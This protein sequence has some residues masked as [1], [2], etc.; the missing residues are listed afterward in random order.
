MSALNIDCLSRSNNFPSVED[1]GVSMQATGGEDSAITSHYF[2]NPGHHKK[3]LR[4]V[5]HGPMQ[6]DKSTRDSFDAVRVLERKERN[7]KSM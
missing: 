7:G 2:G 5:D 6:R 3:K 1:H 4:C